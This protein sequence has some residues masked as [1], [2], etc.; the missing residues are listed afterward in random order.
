MV[1]TECYLIINNARQIKQM[2]HDIRGI[3]IKFIVTPIF[4]IVGLLIVGT[5]IQQALD[6]P[7]I[8]KWLLV[9]VAAI[10]ALVAYMRH[11]LSD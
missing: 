9:G 2:N 5:I 8:T 1:A 10:I 4:L 3:F 6:W 7:M 11:I